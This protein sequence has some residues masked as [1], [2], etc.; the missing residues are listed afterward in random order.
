MYNWVISSELYVQP[1]LKA[2][3]AILAFLHIILVVLLIIDQFL[4]IASLRMLH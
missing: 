3:S 4:I 1:A 2:V